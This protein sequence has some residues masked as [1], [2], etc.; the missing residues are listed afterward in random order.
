MHMKFS[1]MLLTGFGTLL[2][3]SDRGKHSKRRETNEKFHV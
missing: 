1:R 2:L 3:S